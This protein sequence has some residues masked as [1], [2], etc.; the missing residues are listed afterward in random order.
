MVTDPYLA[1]GLPHGASKKDIKAAYRTLAL[2]FHPDRNSQASPE[3]IYRAT[4]QFTAI[5]TAYALLNDEQR[6][7]DYD[8]IYKYG[9]YDNNNGPLEHNTTNTTIRSTEL[10]SYHTPPPH[11]DDPFNPFHNHHHNSNHKRVRGI[12]YA[13][14]D[15]LVYV[16]SGGKRYSTTIAGVHIPPRMNL[17]A[18]KVSYSNGTKFHDHEGQVHHVTKTTQ[19]VHGKKYTKVETTT[20]YPDGKKEVLIEEGNDYVERR[21]T[22]RPKRK[23]QPLQ[24]DNVTHSG[25]QDLPWYRSAWTVLRDKLT[26]CQN[27]CGTMLVQ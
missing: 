14:Q 1:L 21:V 22:N 11:N 7:R 24:E 5:S 13:L 12:G 17:A 9:G 18:I 10:P 2:K 15:P 19:F 4:H 3:Q 23:P 25:E 8:H 27:S 20:L 6:K 26:S 16:L